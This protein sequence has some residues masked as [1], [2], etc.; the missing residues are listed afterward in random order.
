MANS[1]IKQREIRKGKQQPPLHPSPSPSPSAP[2]SSL[3][4]NPSLPPI[5]P[6]DLSLPVLFPAAARYPDAP[7]APCSCASTAPSRRD[8]ADGT[9][10]GEGGAAAAAPARRGGGR[11]T[12]CDGGHGEGSRFSVPG[13]PLRRLCRVAHEVAGQERG[14]SQGAIVTTLCIIVAPLCI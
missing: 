1:L 12:L 14:R 9:P 7:V 10:S 13:P 4:P 5:P 3:P 6:A 2:S 11:H 8:P